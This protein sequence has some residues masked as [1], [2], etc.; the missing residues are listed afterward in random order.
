MKHNRIP[1]VAASA[2]VVKASNHFGARMSN[3]P[4]D[5]IV[6]NSGVRFIVVRVPLWRAS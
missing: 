5:P 6:A 1:G 4:G 2:A 3:V